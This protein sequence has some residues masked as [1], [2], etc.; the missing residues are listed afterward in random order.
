MRQGLKVCQLREHINERTALPPRAG[1]ASF[2]LRAN[3]KCIDGSEQVQ[4]GKQPRQQMVRQCT[5]TMW[6]GPG[7]AQTSTASRLCERSPELVSVTVLEWPRVSQ[8]SGKNSKV[9]CRWMCLTLCLLTA[10]GS[11]APTAVCVDMG[12]SLDSPIIKFL[13]QLTLLPSTQAVSKAGNG[14]RNQSDG[15]EAGDCLFPKSSSEAAFRS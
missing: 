1:A 10:H 4:L 12:K 8:M 6:W 7:R 3:G 13:S 14:S 15:S 9:I 5:V 11:E 2:Y